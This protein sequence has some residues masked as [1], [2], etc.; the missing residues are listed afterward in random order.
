MQYSIIKTFFITR[1]KVLFARL[2]VFRSS[3]SPRMY[4]SLHNKQTN[5]KQSLLLLVMQ[6]K[7]IPIFICIKE[8]NTFSVKKE[9][10]IASFYKSL[11][12]KPFVVKLVAKDYLCKT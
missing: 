10:L 4:F 9:I 1:T 3:A 2:I 5:I 12:R 6:C 11:I 8:H 7:L